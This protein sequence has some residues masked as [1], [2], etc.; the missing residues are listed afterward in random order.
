MIKLIILG[1]TLSIV[2]SKVVAGTHRYLEVEGD[3]KGDDWEDFRKWVHFQDP[4]RTV[5]YVLPMHNDKITAEQMLDLTAGTWDVHVHGNLPTDDDDLVRIETEIRQLFVEGDETG[6]PFPPLTPELSEI[7]ANDVEQALDIAQSVRDDADAGEFDGATFT[8]DVDDEGNISWTN[9]QGKEN[10]E[11]KNIR[12]PQGLTGESGVYIG[13][14]EPTDPDKDVWINPE[15]GIGRVITSIDTSGTHQPGTYDTYTL[16]FNEGEDLVLRVYNGVDGEGTGDMIKNVYDTQNK[17]VD[18]FD[19]ADETAET[20]AASAAAGKANTADLADVAFSGDYDDLN[21]LPTIPPVDSSMSSASTNP[22]QNKVIKQYVDDHA[23]KLFVCVYN[24]TTYDEVTAAIAA[25][26]IPVLPFAYYGGTYTDTDNVSYH[27][28][29]TS[30]AGPG[31]TP[32][33]VVS[34]TDRYI[35]L[36]EN[37]EWINGYNYPL[38][39]SS[40][41]ASIS[42]SSSAPVQSRAIKQALDQKQNTLTIDSA[43]SSTSTNPVQNR[44]VKQYVDSVTTLNID[45]LTVN[46]PPISSGSYTILQIAVPPGRHAYGI[47]G[48]Q[49][50]QRVGELIYTV[51]SFISYSTALQVILANN[52]SSAPTETRTCSVMYLYRNT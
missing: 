46:V 7:L 28:F 23:G 8:P 6:S 25:G 41:L 21:G 43:M 11:A 3:F 18:I 13:T 48:V 42:S 27:V 44:A 30:A 52:N 5:H 35:F 37:D 31:S 40:V 4:G 26:K 36:S 24:S 14:T 19:Y 16:H 39:T 12:G 50:T 15:G 34:V 2:T 49:V 9:D 45:T 1:Q 22:V 17:S 20:A 33:A 29:Y 51:A 38:S 10:P 32:M 47:V